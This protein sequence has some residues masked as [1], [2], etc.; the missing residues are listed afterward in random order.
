LCE[1]GDFDLDMP[2]FSF[3]DGVEPGVVDRGMLGGVFDRV[4]KRHDREGKADA[5]PK[6]AE[7]GEGD[8]DASFFGEDFGELRFSVGGGSG[9]CG[10]SVESCELQGK[11][12]FGLTEKMH[13]HVGIGCQR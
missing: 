4:A 12:A 3:V 13:N 7:F 8:K 6:V 9:Y 1:D 5:S 11:L 10:L 2:E